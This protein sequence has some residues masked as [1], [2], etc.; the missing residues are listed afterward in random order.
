M[1]GIVAQENSTIIADSINDSYM[2]N[3][4]MRYFDLLRNSAIV[5]T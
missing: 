1:P 2:I 5:L 4:I 3:L